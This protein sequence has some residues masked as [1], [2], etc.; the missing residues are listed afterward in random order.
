MSVEY[1]C[2]D[3]ETTGLGKDHEVVEISVIRCRDKV[4]ITRF[5]A[6]EH[7]ERASL[8]A[9]AICNKTMN[10]LKIGTSKEEAVDDVEKFLN[11]D[12]ST[13]AHR[14]I[15]GHNIINFD[16]RFLHALWTKCGR[17][18][19]ANMFLDTMQMARQAAKGMGIVKPKVNLQ[20]S[21]DLFGIKKTATFHNS[22][23]D[24]RNTFFLWKKL[25]EE[26]NLDYLPMIKT[27][28]HVV[29]SS[30]QMSDI[31]SLDLNDVM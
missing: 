30:E 21:C 17:T 13:P 24:T 25:V 10:D 6:A 4:Q 1:Y 16:L 8:D 12:G 5:I 26:I 31:D 20:A 14:C 3:L 19:P 2:L 9:L 11:E 28:P 15:V 29:K 22:K 23:M 7:P 18:F 27:L